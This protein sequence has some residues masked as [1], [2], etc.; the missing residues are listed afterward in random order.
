MISPN[1][2]FMI[3]CH[4]SDNHMQYMLVLTVNDINSTVII[5]VIKDGVLVLM[6][7]NLM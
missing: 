4:L 6:Q 5:T 1:D 7:Q 3:I 2:T